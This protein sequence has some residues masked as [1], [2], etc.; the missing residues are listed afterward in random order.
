M[1]YLA[2]GG[3]RPVYGIGGESWHIH[4]VYDGTIPVNGIAAAVPHAVRE[5]KLFTHSA[6]LVAAHPV[7]HQFAHQSNLLKWILR[8]EAFQRF[9]KFDPM[10]IFT[11][12]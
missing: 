2:A 5:G 4:H 12:A 7:A 6:G 10:G 1:A 9:D 11:D 3:I 8:R